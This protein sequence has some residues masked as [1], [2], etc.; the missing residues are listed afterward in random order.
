[1]LFPF[2]E[3]HYD[4][5]REVAG[6][7]PQEYRKHLR[8]LVGDCAILVSDLHRLNG[9]LGPQDRRLLCSGMAALLAELAEFA[10]SGTG[11]THP[12]AAPIIARHLR[13]VVEDMD[14]RTVQEQSA[15]AV[16]AA[17]RILAE[18]QWR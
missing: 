11:L 9:Y 1:M 3:E 13:K 4:E 15:S 18:A 7:A 2:V 16:D 17:A 10:L 6:Q 12:E 5:A 14:G 8:L